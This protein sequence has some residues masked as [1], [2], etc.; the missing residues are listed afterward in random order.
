L[1]KLEEDRRKAEEYDEKEEI[2][3][4][5]A[6]IKVKVKEKL[7]TVIKMEED[8]ALLPKNHGDDS[9][10]SLRSPGFLDDDNPLP[11]FNPGEDPDA[12]GVGE[13]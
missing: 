4:K 7:Q 3:K 9:E 8:L 2:L 13:G 6:E 12:Q 5:K 1:A 11:E 10:N